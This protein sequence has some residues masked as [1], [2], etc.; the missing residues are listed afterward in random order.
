MKYEI[1]QLKDKIRFLRVEEKGAASQPANGAGQGKE[2]SV[3]DN[4]RY[5]ISHN[6]VA[7]R[8]S[9]VCNVY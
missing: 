8:C 1:R 5:E 9:C 3:M 2:V 7:L 6:K 4:R